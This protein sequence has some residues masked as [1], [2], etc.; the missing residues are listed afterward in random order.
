MKQVDYWFPIQFYFVNVVKKGYIVKR[1]YGWLQAL[2]Y[3]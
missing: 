3:I 2:T 1:I